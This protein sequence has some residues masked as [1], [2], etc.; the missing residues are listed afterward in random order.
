MLSKLLL[1]TAC[2]WALAAGCTQQVAIDTEAERTAVKTVLDDYVKSVEAED[3]RLYAQNV[4]HDS[5][6]VNFGAFGG[7]IVGWAA[8]EEVINGQNE[9][10][11]DVK[12]DVSDM[13]VHVSSDGKMAWATTLWTFS[14]NTP[15]G[16]IELPVR[17]TWV[18]EKEQAGWKIVHFHKSIAAG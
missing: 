4:R 16:S 13:K 17:C 10:L 12:I 11:A 1:V 3:M 5:V 2:T 14:G 9:A 7:P 15:D 8:L 18:L 6:M